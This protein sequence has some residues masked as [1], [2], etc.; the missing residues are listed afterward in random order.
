MTGGLT[1]RCSVPVPAASRCEGVVSGVK[2][3]ALRFVG[4][5]ALTLNDGQNLVGRMDM[6]PGSGAI[7][8]EDGNDLQFLALL[9]RDQVMHVNRPLE[10]FRVREPGDGSV[11]L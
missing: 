1:G 10:M 5:D 4:Y 3:L 8:E 7:V 11:G 9:F 2:V 6:G